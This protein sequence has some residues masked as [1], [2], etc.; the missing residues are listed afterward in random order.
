MTTKF[1]SADFFINGSSQT[2]YYAGIYSFKIGHSVREV[3]QLIDIVTK[4]IDFLLLSGNQCSQ[5]LFKPVRPCLKNPRFVVEINSKKC[6]CFEW[7]SS[8]E[9][10]KKKMK[11][12]SRYHV[13]LK[14]LPPFALSF[15]L[16][17]PP[18]L[19]H[20]F[21]PPFL[22]LCSPPPRYH[23]PLPLPPEAT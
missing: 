13:P 12:A 1:C 20:L 18:S 16:N 15:P 3:M 7:E 9:Q 4:I 21:L 22:T 2:S 14:S 10:I 19:S 23:V 8:K 11:K 17:F 5:L 6:S